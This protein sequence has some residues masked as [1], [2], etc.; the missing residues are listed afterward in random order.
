MISKLLHWIYCLDIVYM[1]LLLI[2]CSALFCLA[3]N[4]FARYRWWKVLVA[5]AL[6]IVTA[7]AIYTT[8]GNR[9][10][11]ETLHVNLT[12]LHSYREVLNGGNPEIYRSNFMNAVLFYPIGLLA[13]ALLPKK[14]SGILRR[15][16]TIIFCIMLSA[17]IEYLQYTFSL[18]RCEIDDVIHNVLG[19]CIGSVAM[20]RMPSAI[21]S[22]SEK[23]KQM[24][25]Q[26]IDK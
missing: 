8:L 5:I 22:V 10:G 18:G 14:W 24:L 21:E 16:L 6:L 20:L 13:T 12:P 25:A 19:G 26:E 11:G 2:A 7:G 15:I 23:F 17:R 1:V 3:H 9:G 4:C